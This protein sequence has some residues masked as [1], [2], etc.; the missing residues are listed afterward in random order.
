WTDQGTV[1]DFKRELKGEVESQLARGGYL[2]AFISESSLQSRHVRIEL[3]A[4]A[5]RWPEQILPALIDPVELYKL[6]PMLA[7][8]PFVTLH[9]S[10]GQSW[11]WNRVDD[12][13]VRIY[14]LVYRNTRGK[15]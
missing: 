7:H 3:E 10:D 14:Y 1:T 11:D 6:P 15:R 13:I 9:R 4:A 8:R 2:V 12:L 5:E